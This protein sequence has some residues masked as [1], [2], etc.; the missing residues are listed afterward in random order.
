M[1][2]FLKPGSVGSHK[3]IPFLNVI[4]GQAGLPRVLGVLAIPPAEIAAFTNEE[5]VKFPVVPMEGAWLAGLV[6]AFPSAVLLNDGVIASGRLGQIPDH[7]MGVVRNVYNQAS[8]PRPNPRPPEKAAGRAPAPTPRPWTPYPANATIE[9]RSK[10][11]EEDFWHHYF[12]KS[13]PVIMTDM[14]D[15]WPAMSH[16]TPQYLAEKYGEAEVEIQA[17]RNADADYEIHSGQLKKKVRFKDYISDVLH[18]GAT[19]DYYMVANNRNLEQEALKGMTDG[20]DLSY[21]RDSAAL[22]GRC[23]LWFGPRGTITPLH[24]DIVPV[25]FA[26]IQGRK[27]WRIIPPEHSRYLYNHI[28]V[29]SQVDAENPDYH[30]HPLYAK[31]IST[32]VVLNPGEMIFMPV[33]WWHQVKALDVSISFSY[34]V[35][36]PGEAKE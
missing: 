36:P 4:H 33:G 10:L 12:M 24:Y 25:L 31:A 20:V 5:K 7:L 8:Q 17:S 23:F 21:F 29:F 14:M 18:G 6:D 27:R 1:L 32:D 2:V 9:R 16:W 15:N 34:S 22:A 26:Q 13:R 30:A 3:W 11:S 35:K 19:N 28:G